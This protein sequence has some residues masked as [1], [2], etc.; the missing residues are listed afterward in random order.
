M[1]RTSDPDSAGSQ[2]FLCLGR[3]PHL[4][5]QYTVFGRTADE[6]SLAVV[7]AIGA[8]PTG[9]GDQPT[10]LVKMTKVSVIETPL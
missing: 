6:A 8:V 3:V 9:A 5:N 7:L 4:D 2:F 10:K 1:A